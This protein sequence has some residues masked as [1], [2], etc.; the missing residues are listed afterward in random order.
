[1]VSECTHTQCHYSVYI[2]VF[3]T[4]Y[5]TMTA[6]QVSKYSNYNIVQYH[7]TLPSTKLIASSIDGRNS[8]FSIAARSMILSTCGYSKHV[9]IYVL[10]EGNNHTWRVWIHIVK[11]FIPQKYVLMHVYTYLPTAYCYLSIHH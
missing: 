6:L 3:T 7:C 1:M 8:R 9:C 4:I 11:Y 10:Y 5:L 2:Q